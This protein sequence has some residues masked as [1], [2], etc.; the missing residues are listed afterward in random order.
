[1][2]RCAR[3]ELQPV[4]IAPSPAFAAPMSCAFARDRRCASR[5]AAIA[6]SAAVLSGPAFATSA[7]AA[8][9][10]AHSKH[11]P[12]KGGAGG[13]KG[14]GSSWAGSYQ[15]RSQ[16]ESIAAS[17]PQHFWHEDNAV[18]NA[19]RQPAPAG[20]PAPWTTVHTQTAPAFRIGRFS[21]PRLDQARQRGLSMLGAIPSSPQIHRTASSEPRIQNQNAPRIA[22]PV[23]VGPGQRSSVKL[24]L[25]AKLIWR[26]NLHNASCRPTSP[27]RDLQSPQTDT[28]KGISS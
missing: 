21:T 7:E 26:G 2:S 1:M 20:N 4:S 8:R 18:A 28:H 12:G 19:E 23:G 11:G 3:I 5:I 15:A 16:Q 25:L 6:F 14:T 17:G 27:S 10:R 22:D 13:D 24:F 9:A